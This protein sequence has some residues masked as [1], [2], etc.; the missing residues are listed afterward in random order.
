MPDQMVER[1]AIMTAPDRDDLKRRILRLFD[2]AEGKRPN[3]VLDFTDN[4]QLIK[5]L[6]S[7]EPHEI[8]AVEQR[9]LNGFKQ[10]RAIQAR[11]DRKA[12]RI[13]R[14]LVRNSKKRTR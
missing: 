2:L 4:K 14:Q 9:V 10:A 7:L 3:R 13:W 11:A 12:T 5:R 1:L 8:D 6:V